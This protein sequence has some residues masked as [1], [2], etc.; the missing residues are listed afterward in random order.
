ML[1]VGWL[2]VGQ[3]HAGVDAADEADAVE[4]FKR[5]GDFA[6]LAPHVIEQRPF[7]G[8]ASYYNGLRF[9]VVSAEGADVLAPDQT[10][11]LAGGQWL[12]AAGRF[13]SAVLEN[14]GTPIEIGEGTFHVPGE[15]PLDLAAVVVRNDRLGA[16]APA[17]DQLR[18]AHLWWPIDRLA[19][20]VEWSLVQLHMRAG[21]D[22][23][24]SLVVFTVVLKLLLVPLGILTVRMQRQ[25]SLYQGKLAPVL[26]E[27]KANY[28]GEE[29]HKRIMAAHRELGIS[30]FYVLKP[31][32]A[33]FI[34]VP[35]WV[36]VFNALG[37][38]PQLEHARFLWIESL[39]YPDA[40]AVLPFAIPLFGDRVSLLPLLMTAV[41]LLSAALF[42]DRLAPEGELQRQK[43]NLYLIALCFLVLFYPFPAGMVLYWTLSNALQILQ[44]RVVRV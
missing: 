7:Y 11:S 2:A 24:W 36:A 12:V 28:D 22:W 10:V 40:L 41:T 32:L 27:I 16:V 5:E 26:A 42:R 43:R 6:V 9:F 23:G 35:V 38:M 13:R 3:L 4:R 15:P 44:Q 21:L 37:E 39:A 29:A 18:Y 14:P 8:L 25:V 17:L 33:M 1:L 20:T 31:M 30:T 34:Q 19:R